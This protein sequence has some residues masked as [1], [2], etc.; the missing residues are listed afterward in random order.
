M[1]Y[2]GADHA[3]YAL[4]E[5][6]KKYLTERGEPFEDLGTHS[7]ESVDFPVYAFA[8]GEK[9]AA[10]EREGKEDLGIL[11]CGSGVG[12]DIAANKVKGVRAALATTEY[13]GAQSR[14]HDNANVLVLSGRVI[15]GKTAVAITK[16]FLDAR[17][18]AEEKYI[19]RMNMVKAYE[20]KQSSL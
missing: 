16:A 13:M 12:M 9:V 5:E 20:D 6:V 8:V 1:L 3:G 7:D 14:E 2:V 19:R 10:A 18:L 15:D 17:F 11:L 4:K